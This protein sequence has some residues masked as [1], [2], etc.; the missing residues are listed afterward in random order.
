MNKVTH[1]YTYATQAKGQR[2]EMCLGVVF[3]CLSVFSPNLGGECEKDLTFR[4]KCSSLLIE[5]R[6][7]FQAAI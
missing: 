7:K 3:K 5:I 6:Y 2:L 1:K 4:A